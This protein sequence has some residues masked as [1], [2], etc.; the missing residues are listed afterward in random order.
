MPGWYQIRFYSISHLH[1]LTYHFLIPVCILKY[2]WPW[3][4]CHL[5]I[6]KWEAQGA[7]KTI[8]LVAQHLLSKLKVICKTFDSRFVKH[9]QTQQIAP[10]LALAKGQK[11][12]KSNIKW[13][14]LDWAI[15]DLPLKQ[16]G[17]DALCQLMFRVTPVSTKASLM[18][19]RQARCAQPS[20]GNVSA[21]ALVQG[22]KRKGRS[23]AGALCKALF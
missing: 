20:R 23:I 6:S 14:S 8:L 3:S 22:K 2:S 7:G 5:T 15:L 16:L 18:R 11:K 12:K 9:T 21:R 10:V 4:Q 17:A 13:P 19:P 1:S